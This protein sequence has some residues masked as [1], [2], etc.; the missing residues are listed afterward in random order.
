MDSIGF[1]ECFLKIYQ[2]R[3]VCCQL[4]GDVLLAGTGKEY[5][6]IYWLLGLLMYA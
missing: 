2:Q 4:R 6:L 5:P 1:T 3:D